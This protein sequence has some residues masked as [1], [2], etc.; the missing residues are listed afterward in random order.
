[1]EIIFHFLQI[2]LQF[3]LVHSIFIVELGEN[4]TVKIFLKMADV[5]D[6][7]FVWC[8]IQCRVPCGVVLFGDVLWWQGRRSL[9]RCMSCSHR[10][11]RRT[12]KPR[13]EQDL[14]TCSSL[15]AMLRHMQLYEYVMKL[16]SMVM[17]LL[18]ISFLFFRVEV[19]G[20]RPSS[21]VG[22]RRYTLHNTL[23][24]EDGTDR[25]SQE[26]GK[27]LLTHGTQY[28]RKEGHQRHC[29]GSLKSRKKTFPTRSA[30]Q[31]PVHSVFLTS[32]H[33]GWGLSKR[34]DVR[35][36]SEIV[37]NILKTEHFFFKTTHARMFVF[38]VRDS[39]K[40]SLRR[41]KP[42]VKVYKV[43]IKL[44]S[45]LLLAVNVAKLSKNSR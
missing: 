12:P 37:L 28:P 10:G 2:H 8:F 31:N 18:L 41:S 24:L 15:T 23:F 36:A 3:S 34:R 22:G 30:F 29:C 38:S 6:G 13:C 43:E 39:L 5:G 11:L 25:L 33:W 17:C 40:V 27:Q 42:V 16:C 26:L 32:M 20:F 35:V 21:A 1:M 4:R 9:K 45:F 14:Y 7:W 19:W 44:L